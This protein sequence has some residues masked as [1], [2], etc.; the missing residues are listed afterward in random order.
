M[1][2]DKDISTFEDAVHT[3]LHL[4]GTKGLVECLNKISCDKGYDILEDSLKRTKDELHITEQKYPEQTKAFREIIEK[5]YQ[6][7]LQKNADYSPMNILGTGIVGICTRIWDKTAR[8]LSLLGCNLSTGEYSSERRS[9]NDEPIED[10]LLDLA[11][12]CIIG[13]IFRAGKWGK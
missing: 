7:Y 6:I 8:I 2:T 4:G 5:M 1:L 13:L 11:V 9:D 3:I 10:N 12:Y